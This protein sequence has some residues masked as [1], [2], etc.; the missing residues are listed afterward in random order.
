MFLFSHIPKQWEVKGQ[1]SS[2]KITLESYEILEH[3]LV[4]CRNGY[5]QVGNTE[6]AI[7]PCQTSMQIQSL[8]SS[9]RSCK[10]Y[11]IELLCQAYSQ[12]DSN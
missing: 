12:P 1:P 9:E 11:P 2:S 6:R 4:V 10:I 3:S 7:A 5:E 8:M